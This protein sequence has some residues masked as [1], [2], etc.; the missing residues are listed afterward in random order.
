MASGR[1][2][3]DDTRN[4]Q[5]RSGILPVLPSRY[6]A[7]QVVGT[8]MVPS[9]VQERVTYN[10]NQALF[11]ERG[12]VCCTRFDDPKHGHCLTYRCGSRPRGG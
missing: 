6:I 11:G 9:Q 1:I 8:E 2:N 10:A 4:N 3:T 12:W 7:D 5:E